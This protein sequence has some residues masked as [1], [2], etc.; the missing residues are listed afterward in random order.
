MEKV[1]T[2]GI[3]LAKNV[4]QLHGAD[5]RGKVI[6]KRKLSRKKVIPF[7]TNLKPCLV[8]IKACAGSNYWS[9]EIKKLGHD[10]KLISPQFVKPYVENDKTDSNDA[11]AICEAVTRPHMRFVP[12][13][14]VE[15]QDIQ[16][17]PSS[18]GEAR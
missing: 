7:L 9:R 12:V 11:A 5:S 14:K 15:Q 13:K 8:G 4:F 16:T 10:V 17:I 1:S 2:I 6:F 18:K 3:D